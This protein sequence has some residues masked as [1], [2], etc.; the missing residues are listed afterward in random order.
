LPPKQ[1]KVPA[2]QSA[3]VRQK[4]PVN[5]LLDR[6]PDAYTSKLDRSA[7]R[8]LCSEHF[9]SNLLSTSMLLRTSPGSARILAHRP[10]RRFSLVSGAFF[11]RG[12]LIR[13]SAHLLLAKDYRA[14]LL[15]LVTAFQKPPAH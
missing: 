12:A 8:T 10:A 13:A 7:M 5:R 2:A 6:V 15:G 9:Q 11:S 3:P 4:N 1:E 14:S